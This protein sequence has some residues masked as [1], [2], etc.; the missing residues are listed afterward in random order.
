MEKYEKNLCSVYARY[1]ALFF[2]CGQ[3]AQFG[4]VDMNKVQQESQV[5]KDATADLQSKGKAMGR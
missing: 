3:N 4:V 5:F 1:G 2:R